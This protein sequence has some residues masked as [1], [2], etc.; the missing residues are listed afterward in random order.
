MLF[1][2][3]NEVCLL[4]PQNNIIDVHFE[5]YRCPLWGRKHV[6]ETGSKIEVGFFYPMI[7]ENPQLVT[8]EPVEV[9]DC[10]KITNPLRG[11]SGIYLNLIKENRPKDVNM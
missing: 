2:S 4:R 8:N 10:K 6:S 5:I 1:P 9:R 11:I 3:N 7:G